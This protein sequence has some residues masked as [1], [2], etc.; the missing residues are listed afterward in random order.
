MAKFRILAQSID[1]VYIDVEAEDEDQAM[2]MYGEI[3][4]GS[5]HIEDGAWS[6]DDIEEL[7]DDAEVDFT[8]EEILGLK[9]NSRK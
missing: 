9:Y 7:D 5:Y 3:D 2:E 4:G 8:A 6:F 1:Y